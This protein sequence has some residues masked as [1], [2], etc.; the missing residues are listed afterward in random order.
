MDLKGNFPKLSMMD[1]INDNNGEIELKK[2]KL[3]M[4]VFLSIIY[5]AI[6]KDMTK[7]NAES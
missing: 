4:T 1:I 3:D 2:F 7:R 5:N 6:F